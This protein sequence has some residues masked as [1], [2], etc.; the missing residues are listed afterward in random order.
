M[1]RGH[2]HHAT[3]VMP[4]HKVPGYRNVFIDAS[5]SVHHHMLE[6]HCSVWPRVTHGR[7]R[8][9]HVSIVLDETFTMRSYLR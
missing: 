4:H 6:H 9:P 8:C 7:L 2:P 1:I 3:Q 5:V